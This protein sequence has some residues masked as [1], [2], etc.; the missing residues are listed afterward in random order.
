MYVVKCGNNTCSSGNT[1][2]TIAGYAGSGSYG[3][4]SNITI[5]N[6]GFPI[7][8]SS[9]GPA[10]ATNIS[11]NLAV[12]HCVDLTCS[13]LSAS[14]RGGGVS[15]GSKALPYSGVYTDTINEGRDPSVAPLRVTSDRTIYANALTA[16]SDGV[17]KVSSTASTAFLVQNADTGAKLFNVNGSANRV[18]IMSTISSMTAPTNL[19]VG[20]VTSGGSLAT[21]SWYYYKVTAIDSMGGETG[22]SNEATGL[23]GGAGSQTLPVTWTSVTGATAYKVY[24]TAANGAS[25]SEVYITTVLTNSF[26]DSGSISAG[27]ATV[28]ST[29]SAYT[30]ANQLDK[31]GALTVGGYG[32][33]TGQLYVSGV[34]P[35]AA[36]GTATMG[37]LPTYVTVQGRYAYVV[38][39]T[40]ATL[41]VVDINNKENPVVTGSVATGTAPRAV[42]VQGRYAYVVNQTSNTL[43]II[44]VSNPSSPTS[45]STVTTGLAPLALQVRG[46]YAFV[47]NGTS[48]S[49]Q[50]FDISNAS[51]PTSVGVVTTGTL[52]RAISIQGN[53]AY[54]TNF[55][56]SSLQVI[57]IANVASPSVVG[58]VTTNLNAPRQVVVQGRYAYVA[59]STGNNLLVFDVSNPSSPTYLSGLTL[60]TTPYALAVQGR[61]AYVTNFLSSPGN[62]QTID[63]SNP[64]Q[65]FSVGTTSTGT[66]SNPNAIAVSGRYAYVTSQTTNT[67]QVFDLGGTYS[68]ALEAGSAEFGS[69]NVGGQST[70]TGDASFQGGVNVGSSLQIGANFGVA[71]N[72]MIQGA[73]SVAGGIQGGLTITGVA[74]PSAPTVTNVGTAG[75]TTYSYTITAVSATGGESTA[76]TAGTTATGNATLSSTNYNAITWTPVAGAV[77]YKVY[78]TVGGATQGLLATTGSTYYFDQGAAGS[79]SAPTSDTTG[80]LNVTGNSLFKPATNGASAFKVQNA[81]GSVDL[82]AIDT[83]GN[84][85]ISI[86][87]AAD[88]GTISIGTANS[89]AVTI[90]KSGG[91]GTLT[92]YGNST[93]NGTLTVNGHVLSGNTSGTTTVAANANCG[94]GCTTSVSGNDSAGVITINVG[95]GAAAGTQVTV[96][97][98]SAYGAAPVVIVT[99]KAVPAASNYPQY[100]I[101][102]STTTFDLKSYNALT[103][104]QTYTFTYIIV[105]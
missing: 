8:A 35:S 38:N 13:V 56:S 105:Q 103:D 37:T 14:V 4:V 69:V 45:V 15:L 27:T 29:G 22:A 104:S 64:A 42:V 50:I 62:F 49:L 23:T 71:G 90:G 47:L 18:N 51:T 88:S 75:V 32:T 74:A 65:P 54:I 24:R 81:A 91:T 31:L 52:P 83:S 85:A 33:P 39:Q 58:T 77:S 86:Q 68:Q 80:S 95:T 53:Y 12:T 72:A 5:G 20:A 70:F 3:Q 57:S 48:N 76:S 41:Q 43:Q 60:G 66:S 73:L 55:T 11:K 79:G 96:T 63:I 59:N 102:S 89:V 61:Y 92:V 101:G 16:S 28:P 46:R 87:A 99:P 9:A 1:N 2:T 84:G 93:F 94:T 6:D 25:N 10:N 17:V 7:I 78:R 82:F 21:S 34:I 67:F 40:S 100:Y 26:T 98:A 30:A 36:A 19:A 44:D 97:F